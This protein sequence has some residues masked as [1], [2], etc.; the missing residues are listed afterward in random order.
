MDRRYG[1]FRYIAYA[2]EIILLF[3]LQTTPDLLPEIC[4]GKPVLLIPAALSIAFFEQEIPSMFYG[5]A[6]G[7]VIDLSSSDNIG[8]YAFTLTLICFVVSQIFRDYMVVNLLNSL[9]F[10]AGTAFVLIFLH[11]MFFYLMAGKSQ[12]GYYFV[13][14]YVSRIIYTTGV[15]PVL[16]GLNRFLFR[17]LRDK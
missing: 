9:A 13:H 4:G 16:Y 1:V 2:L 12:P 17:S 11:F 3:V 10:S 6:C 7:I 15:S 14:H 5:L 8:F